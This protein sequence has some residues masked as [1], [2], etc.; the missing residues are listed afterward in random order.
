MPHPKKPQT[1][2]VESMGE[3]ALLAARRVLTDAVLQKLREQNVCPDDLP[4]DELV[5]RIFDGQSGV[6]PWAKSDGPGITIEFTERES[7]DLVSQITNLAHDAEFFQKSLDTATG[8]F[9]RSLEKD[10]SE[11]KTYEESELYGFRRRLEQT[12]G[13]P[14]DNFRM[15]LTT[16]R[17][18]FMQEAES[19]RRSKARRKELREALL[20]IHAR[21]LRTATAI[22]ALLEN[23]LADDAYARWRTLYELSV[24]SAFL[25]EHGQNA[26]ERYLAHEFV[27][28]KKRL[29]NALSWGEKKI[30]KK[31]QREIEKDYD[32][33]ISKYGR[34]FKNDYGWAAS[35]IGNDN[36]KFV[37]IEESVKGRRIVPPYKE[38]S[39]QVHGG[40][41]GLLG[42]SSS[43][44][45]T[46]IG[47]SDLGLDIPLMHSA[48]CLMQVTITHLHHSPSRDLVYIS[49]LIALNEK[50]EQ[51]CRRVAHKLHKKR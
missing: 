9:L 46:A 13:R 8:F 12:W 44:N 47:H 30:T 17:D 4:I 40:R 23:G 3:S 31:Q 38:S 50:I 10:W 14:L 36:P 35:F 1:V 34:S 15:M 41:A 6:F 26:A 49:A 32:W 20:G 27:S 43:D 16:S 5:D 11:R 37:N 28:L 18:S 25:S 7:K 29:N 24:V 33:A 45:L 22:I 42:L 21:A 51:Q 48:L 2:L 39:Q 19:L